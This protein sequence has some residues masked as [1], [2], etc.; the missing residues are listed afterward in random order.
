MRGPA[1]TVRIALEDVRWPVAPRDVRTRDEATL[2]RTLLATPLR[3][4]RSGRLARGL[5]SSWHSSNSRAWEFRCTHAAAVAR[6]VPF[7]R[8][9]AHGNNVRVTLPFPW[10]RFPY[11]LTAAQ[12]AVPGT[13]GP[14]TLER[15]AP[16]LVVARRGVLRLVFRRVEPHRAA[17]LFRRGDLD[18]APVPPGDIRAAQLDPA[19]APAVRVA[20]LLAVDAVVFG[21]AHG[22]LARL[23][24]VRR[25]YWQTAQR[26]DYDAL[27]PEEQAG[28]A[29]SLLPG[30]VPL[31]TPA[32]AYRA[33][34]AAIPTLPIKRAGIGA[35][36]GLGY[37]RDLLVAAWRDLSLGPRPRGRDGTLLRLA[38]TY[39]QDEAV[40]ASLLLRRDLP[41]RR[42]FLKALGEADQRGDLER[43]DDALFASAAVVPVAWAVDA[44]LVSPRVHGW[45]EDAL[46]VPDYTR[47]TLR[48]PATIPSR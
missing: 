34:R 33:A 38:A 40:L 12:A 35:G 21:L 6:A 43:A 25:A 1:H 39:P 48:S 23:P 32:R 36:P 14:F 11:L 47:V 18:E 22:K 26:S 17:A 27:V 15:A 9:V 31:R 7:G 30:Y 29:V 46:G 2:V 44:R 24:D 16:G 45:R 28:V 8:A 10:V 20:P 19:L 3:L 4:T 37:G 5:C 13:R 41:G 42:A